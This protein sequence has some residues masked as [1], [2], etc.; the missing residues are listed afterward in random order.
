MLRSVRDTANPFELAERTFVR[1]FRLTR[2]A[3]REVI[4]LIRPYGNTKRI[5]F[6]LAA[7]G[8]LFFLAHGSYQ[9]YFG[10]SSLYSVSQPTISRNLHHIV[11]L[12][13]Q[14]VLPLELKFPETDDEFLRLQQGFRQQF[15]PTLQNIFGLIDGTLIAIRSPAI[16]DADFPARI[17]RT[18]KGFTGLNVLVITA[19]D[20]RFIYLNAR[21]PGSCHDS[22]IF[23]TSFARI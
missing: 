5:P 4:N 8:T 12:L 13:I 6:D 19:S 10:I 22:A 2:A 17:Y 16:F 18:R 20:G 14:H 7:L 15:H 21:H 1:H 11:D 23:R 9:K 3:A